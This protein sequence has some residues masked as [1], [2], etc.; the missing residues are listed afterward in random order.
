MWGN[1]STAEFAKWAP[2]YENKYST[3]LHVSATNAGVDLHS[4]GPHPLPPVSLYPSLSRSR[5]VL[6]IQRYSARYLKAA[7]ILAK[8]GVIA[9]S[10]LSSAT[11]L[12]QLDLEGCDMLGRSS[13][14][15]F[16]SYTRVDEK[17]WEKIK[18]KD[19]REQKPRFYH[20][21]KWRR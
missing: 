8:H 2:D 5:L 19:S 7:H 18:E 10:E 12:H 9:V 17:A 3:R 20:A 15:P 1:A 21:L 11:I 4:I 13:G 6:Q 16:L 14:V